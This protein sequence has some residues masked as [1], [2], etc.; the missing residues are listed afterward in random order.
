ME[1]L[2]VGIIS[3]G[4]DKNRVDSEIVL[5]KLGRSYTITNNPKD[6]DIILVNTCGFI[7]SSKQES[8]NTIIEMSEYKKGKGKCK[9]IVVTGCLT[10]RYGKELQE[11]LPEAD[12]ILGVND[13]D[14]LEEAIDRAL[15]NNEKSVYC[16]YSDVN[17]NEGQRVLTTSK[18]Y[19]YVRIG[20]G[21]SNFCTYCAIPRIRGKYRSRKIESVLEE[22]K[23]LGAQGVK[24]II[25]VAQDT[26][27]YGIDI[28]NKKMLPELIREISKIDDIKWIRVL[29]CY[30]EEITDE[31]INE[32]KVNDKVCK[33]LDIPVQHISNNVLKLMGR[34]GRKEEIVNVIQRLR[35]EIPGMA[36]RTSLIVGFPGESESDFEELKEFVRETKIDKLGVFRYSQE[37]GTPAA[38]MEN[39]IEEEIKEKREKEIM[40][41]QQENSYEINKNKVGKIYEVVVENFDGEYH[42]GRNYEM[43]PEIDGAIYFKC[44]KILNIGDFVKVKIEQNLEYDLMGVV[45]YESS[46]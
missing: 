42:I 27:R 15:V 19:A 39:Q 45:Y 28:Y 2:K 10:Q 5:D 13:Y 35:Q 21:C 30:P 24:E 17:I 38:E 14:K 18:H 46:K 41:I 31:L 36:I 26:T 33:Y 12:V 37:E 6:S 3:L 8:I 44:D 1:K 9:V 25:L 4:C 40:V 22:V 7:E 34:R 16:N 23:S 20:E 32:I 29:Y 43:T 11:L